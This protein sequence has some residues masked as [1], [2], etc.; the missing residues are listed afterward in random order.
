MC[1]ILKLDGQVDVARPF[2][3]V[4]ASRRAEHLQSA[5]AVLPTKLYELLTMAF[6]H[7]G[8]DLPETLPS[9]HSITLSVSV[10]ASR[11][12]RG[13]SRCSRARLAPS[14]TA[15]CDLEQLHRCEGCRSRAA[16]T[17]WRPQS[18]RRRC[19]EDGRRFVPP[20]E[21]PS[22]TSQQRW[23]VSDPACASQRRPRGRQRGR[24]RPTCQR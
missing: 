24:S 11:G 12:G 8:H 2:I 3:E 16:A 4:A 20:V 22:A 1:H 21:R 5:Y 18:W 7:V 17:P 6:E 10:G 23:G 13:G 9:A 19:C 15:G 14:P